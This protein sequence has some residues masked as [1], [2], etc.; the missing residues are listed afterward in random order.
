MKLY[1]ELLNPLHYYILVQVEDPRAV[2]PG[3]LDSQTSLSYELI[4]TTI[5]TH[6]E[7]ITEN[8]N[9]R[10]CGLYIGKI[11]VAFMHFRLFEIFNSINE[12]SAR[13]H[14]Q[15]AFNIAQQCVDPKR[16]SR[17]NSYLD[18]SLGIHICNAIICHA[19]GDEEERDLSI[20]FVCS[21]SRDIL[22]SSFD[23]DEVLYGRAGAVLGMIFLRRY[24]GEELFP[25]S[26]IL[27][28]AELIITKGSQN[29]HEWGLEAGMMFQWHGTMYLGAAHGIA[30]IAMALLEVIN[31]VS[32]ILSPPLYIFC[33]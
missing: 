30:G 14:L 24:V 8:F 9:P 1:L 20:D 21:S 29:A 10:S 4:Q 19:I 12:N 5:E 11:G 23:V 25:I 31:C 27:P 16:S 7:N 18:G 15:Q 13:L 2:P 6:I 22:D 26:T 33:I 3:E 32:G 17:Q 28:I